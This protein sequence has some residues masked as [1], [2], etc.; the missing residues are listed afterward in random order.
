MPPKKEEKKAK[1]AA[2]KIV[3]DKVKI[4]PLLRPET[5]ADASDLDL[6]HEKC[7]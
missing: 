4:C 6:W 1:P 2:A 7:E 5:C 3:A